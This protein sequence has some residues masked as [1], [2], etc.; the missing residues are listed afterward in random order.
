M[1]RKK[2]SKGQFPAVPRCGGGSS[3]DHSGDFSPRALRPRR[4]GLMTT[5]EFDDALPIMLGPGTG[6]APRHCKRVWLGLA[7]R[8][9]E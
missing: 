4:P 8:M 6:L 7:G 2:K 3:L 5:K 9:G 1:P